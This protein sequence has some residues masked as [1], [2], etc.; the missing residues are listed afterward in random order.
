[1]N[2]EFDQDH[3]PRPGPKLDNT[4]FSG[5]PDCLCSDHFA[6]KADE[7]NIVDRIFGV[8]KVNFLLLL[9]LFHQIILQPSRRKIVKHCVPIIPI[10]KSTHGKK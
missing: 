3:G 1:M 10:V 8:M 7:D 6:C 4:I 2:F 9:S 5:P